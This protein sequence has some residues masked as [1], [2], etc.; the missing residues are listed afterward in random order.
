MVYKMENKKTKK[1]IKEII[2]YIIIIVVVLLVKTY[3][4]T[5]IKVNG[6]SMEPTLKHG[7]IMILNEIG[8]HLNGVERFDIVV[9][10]VN[11]ERI[12]KR[13]IGL[14]GDSVEY[15]DSKLYINEEEVL[16]NFISE[17]TLDFSVS[18]DLGY[19]VIPDDY[20]FVVGDNRDN[21]VDSRIIGLVN[22]KQIMGK[23]SFVIY[24][25]K[26]FGNVN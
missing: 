17:D 23:T 3:I 25:F 12:I 5:P 24:P 18:K 26:K 7:D 11:G 1:I 8:Y 9:V 2:S 14:P 4:F 10:N 19:E 20:Y 16:E 6:S 22:S 15:R 21:S 13:V